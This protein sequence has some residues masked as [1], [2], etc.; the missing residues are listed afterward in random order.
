[1]NDQWWQQS[2]VA[3]VSGGNIQCRD[4]ILEATWGSQSLFYMDA[5]LQ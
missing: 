3:T 4:Y 2:V 5:R 1:M